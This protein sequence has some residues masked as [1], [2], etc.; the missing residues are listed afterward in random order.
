VSFQYATAHKPTPI[1]NDPNFQLSFQEI[2]LDAQELLRTVETIALPGTKFTILEETKYSHILRVQTNDYPYPGDLFVDSRFLSFVDGSTPERKDPLPSSAEIL[3]KMSALEGLAYIWGGNWPEG[4]PEL[5]EYYPAGMPDLTQAKRNTKLLSGVDCSG[6]L[7][8]ASNG[9]IPRNTS[10]LINFGKAIP[11]EH[12][13]VDQ[14]VKQIKKL[15]LIVWQGHVICVSSAHTTI[16]SLV[17]KGV[18]ISDLR[19]R[20]QELMQTKQ[21]SHVYRPNCFVIRRW[22]PDHFGTSH[23][24]ND[25]THR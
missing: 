13:D 14:I 20:L 16:E 6:L 22:H 21:P 1:L 15:D 5:L 3:R 2:P 8:F 19:N 9:N 12:L 7:Y 23:R 24:L 4:I 18:I 17:G 10:S 11:I 25:G